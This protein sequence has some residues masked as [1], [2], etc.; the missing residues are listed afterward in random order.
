MLAEFYSWKMYDLAVISSPNS[1]PL[2]H[3]RKQEKS[4]DRWRRPVALGQKNDGV[5]S[6]S[7]MPLT[8]VKQSWFACTRACLIME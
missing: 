8:T 1:R 2:A 6:H 4:I 7:S 3:R 5:T